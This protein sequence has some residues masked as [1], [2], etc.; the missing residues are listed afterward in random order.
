MQ[1]ENI[2]HF[3]GFITA[4]EPEDFVPQWEPFARNFRSRS[5][6]MS[7][8]QLQ[9]T[10]MKR[11]F[12]YLSRHEHRDGNIRF[13]FMKERSSV[14]FPDQQVK[15]VQAGGYTRVQSAAYNSKHVSVMVFVN[16][17]KN[18]TGFYTGLSCS[19]LNIYQAYFENCMFSNVLEFLVPE[20]KTAGLLEELRSVED[21]E[22]SLYREC[23]V[24][25]L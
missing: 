22:V 8:Q 5:G 17:K 25:H 15:V 23:M 2:V 11:R 14:H 9:D 16:H 13:S 3:V 6:G 21:I 19:K 4:I 7:L 10:E 1:K 24:P 20:N 12:K 18:D